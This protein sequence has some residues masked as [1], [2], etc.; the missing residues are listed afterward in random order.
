MTD[1]GGTLGKGGA[2]SPFPSRLRLE[3]PLKTYNAIAGRP[4][5]L[6]HGFQLRTMIVTCS[7]LIRTPVSRTLARFKV[8]CISQSALRFR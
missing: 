3:R 8:V 2:T 4:E 5:F 1:E 6:R 7:G